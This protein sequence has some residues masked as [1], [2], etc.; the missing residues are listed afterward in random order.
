MSVIFEIKWLSCIAYT[1]HNAD[2]IKYKYALKKYILSVLS[3][4]I[5]YLRCLCSVRTSRHAFVTC[6][7][8]STV[9]SFSIHCTALHTSL[10]NIKE[11]KEKEKN[12]YKTG[13][14]TQE[15]KNTVYYNCAHSTLSRTHM[16]GSNNV[17][18]TAQVQDDHFKR[19][20]HNQ[21]NCFIVY[22][23]WIA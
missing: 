15:A 7:H 3:S 1:H 12:Y 13:L 14:L 5:I 20:T 2:L 19:N 22:H 11:K 21:I 18:Q 4:T 17:S 9:C 23:I 8:L 10:A 16:G 6:A